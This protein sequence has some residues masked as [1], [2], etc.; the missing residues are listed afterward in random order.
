MQAEVTAAP[1]GSSSGGSCRLDPLQGQQAEIDV[2][3]SGLEEDAAGSLLR[4]AA[5]GAVLLRGQRRRPPARHRPRAVQGT[6]SLLV[7]KPRRDEP[8]NA[9]RAVR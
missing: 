7:V 1:S 3:D 2:Q 5:A 4:P 8:N 9:S 6:R